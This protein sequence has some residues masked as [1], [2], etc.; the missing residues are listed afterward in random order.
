MGGKGGGSGGGGSVTI[1][2][3]VDDFGSGE[4]SAVAMPSS[5]P[6]S[7]NANNPANG[8]STPSP[9]VSA[10]GGVVGGNGTARKLEMPT[11]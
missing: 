2:Y 7:N 6:S 10:L 4:V 9:Y 11:G 1:F 8:G 3:G 5:S